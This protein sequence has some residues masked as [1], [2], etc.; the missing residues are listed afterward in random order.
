MQSIKETVIN[1]IAPLYAVETLGYGGRLSGPNDGAIV[2]TILNSGAALD[3]NVFID[4][5]PAARVRV[6]SCMSCHGV[7]EWPMNSF[8][9]PGG[10]QNLTDNLFI[11]RPGTLEFNRWMQ[12]RPGN[13]PQDPGTEPLDYDMN[14]AFKALNLWSQYTGK[15]KAALQGAPAPLQELLRHPERFGKNGRLLK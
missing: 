7:A 6:S 15:G 2:Q 14:I 9:L 10:P 11:Y 12:S 4:G 13:V 5:Q 8:L 3:Q 1:P